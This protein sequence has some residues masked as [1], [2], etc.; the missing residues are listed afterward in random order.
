MHLSYLKRRTTYLRIKVASLRQK[1]RKWLNRSTVLF[2]S[3]LLGTA[4][5]TLIAHADRPTLLILFAAMMGLP[6]FFSPTT[7]GGFGIGHPQSPAERKQQLEQELQ[8]LKEENQLLSQIET[9][10]TKHD[11]LTPQVTVQVTV[12]NE[13]NK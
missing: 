8:D 4:H 7:T 5:E 10:K 11:L 12:Q 1:V 3:G 13:D 9:E 6:A 2:V